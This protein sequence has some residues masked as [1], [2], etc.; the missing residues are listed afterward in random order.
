MATFESYFIKDK[1]ASIENKNPYFDLRISE[2]F[3]TKVLEEFDLSPDNSHVIN[4]HVP[5]ENPKGE[6]PVKANGKLIVIDGGFSIPYRKTTG[7]AGYTLIYNSKGFVLAAHEPFHSKLKAIEEERDIVS[8]KIIIEKSLEE[9]LIKDTN[10]G[11]ELTE[12]I[13]VLK[14]LVTAYEKGLIKEKN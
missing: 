7:I 2:D 8:S 12:Q 11:K 1:K 3:I 5:V 4:G 6:N 13:L 9:L 10:T 14:N